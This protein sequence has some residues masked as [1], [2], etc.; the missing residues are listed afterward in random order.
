MQKS[1]SA[2]RQASEQ[3]GGGGSG[4]VMAHASTSSPRAAPSAPPSAGASAPPPPP[5]APDAPELELHDPLY[6]TVTDPLRHPPPYE[7]VIMQECMK[8]PFA[9]EV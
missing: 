9:D 4:V 3:S 6:A 7:S 1:K 8:F 5:T 2:E